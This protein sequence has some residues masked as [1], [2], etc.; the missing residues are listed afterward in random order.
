MFGTRRTV[1]EGRGKSSSVTSIESRVQ[2]SHFARIRETVAMAGGSGR[3][4]IA[5]GIPG[6]WNERRE[7]RED[8]E[9]GP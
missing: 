3:K 5:D 8:D 7:K 1:G 2:A 9:R 4:W 6:F